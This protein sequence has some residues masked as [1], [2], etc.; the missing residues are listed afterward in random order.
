MK[1]INLAIFFVSLLD[2]AS[3]FAPGSRFLVSSFVR[4][5][6]I[7]MSEEPPAAP[8]AAAA[9]ASKGFGKKTEKVEEEV[10]KDEGTKKY[11]RDSKRGVPEY[12]IFMRP[13]NGE[14][15]DWVSHGTFRS[16]QR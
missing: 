8:A 5:S 6:V 15:E 2:L 3:A 14:K 16:L 4:S 10:V 13:A 9:P 11:E 1:L 7:R 12:N